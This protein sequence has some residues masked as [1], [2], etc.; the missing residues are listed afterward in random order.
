LTPGGEAWWRR[1]R[2][3]SR[4]QQAA[5]LKD[6]GSAF[7]EDAALHAP[8]VPEVLARL[9]QTY[10]AFFRRVSAGEKPGFPRSPGQDRSHSCPYYKEEG[11]GARLDNG[12]LV[13]STLGRRGVRWS[14][15]VRERSRP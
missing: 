11:T 4:V 15:P 1:G 13:L 10:Q 7:P 12:F 14:R 3:V 5:D 8:V 2:S 9:A 6:L